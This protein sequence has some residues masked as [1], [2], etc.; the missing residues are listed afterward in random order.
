MKAKEIEKLV[1]NNGWF[2]VRQN[3]SHR[4]YKHETLIGIVVI[5]FH[6]SKDLPKGTEQ[7][8]FKKA[9]IKL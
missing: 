9:G 4:I 2:F 8:I 6:S 7:S 5:P 1:I 3:G